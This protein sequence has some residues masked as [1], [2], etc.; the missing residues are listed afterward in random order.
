MSAVRDRP[1]LEHTGACGSI[2]LICCFERGKISYHT[3]EGS[4][5]KKRDVK[6]NKL[7]RRCCLRSLLVLISISN[8]IFLRIIG[9]LHLNGR[10]HRVPAS[11]LRIVPHDTPGI[12][13][14]QDR[15]EGR[16]E[17]YFRIFTQS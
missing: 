12:S 4:L 10:T 6:S 16:Q 8:V 3:D 11:G 13:G 14:I 5:D 15:N 2:S 1:T 9:S 17:D 7:Q